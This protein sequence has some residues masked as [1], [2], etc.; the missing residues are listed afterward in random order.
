MNHLLIVSLSRSGGKLLRM[1]LDGHPELNVFPF[2]H[3]NRVSKN[4]IPTRRMGAFGRLSADARL[5]TAGSVH[6]ERKLLRLHPHVLVT[7]VMQT[8]RAETADADSLASMYS[9][10]ARAYFPA[11]G[12]PRE[13]IVVNHCGS[14]SR[15]ARDQLDVVF[16]K[17]THLLTIRDPRAVFSSMQGL[18]YRKFTLD[19]VRSG[20]VTASVLERHIGMC[21]TVDSASGYLRAFCKDYQAM[22]AGYA[23]CSDV[24]RI[25][26]EDLVTSP[27]TTMRWLAE[28]LSIGWDEALLTP[29]ELG[30]SHSPN[31]SFARRGNSVH[32]RAADDWV[33]RLAAAERRYIEKT[34]SEEMAALGY[35]P[36]DEGGRPVL[37]AARLLR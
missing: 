22:V 30:A 14:L 20:K 32:A 6:L 24:I 12:R 31:S 27:E 17:G 28:R 13:A 10:L 4:K 21:E 35:R 26:F 9:G 34:L 15:Y 29:T 2:E 23:A 1:L 37:D 36:M 11:V 16:G 18:L 3:W 8:L 5:E 19:E 7:E 25:R 33:E